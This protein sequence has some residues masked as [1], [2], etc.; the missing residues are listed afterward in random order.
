MSDD[1]ARMQLPVVQL[2][3]KVCQLV[4]QWREDELSGFDFLSGGYSN[5]NFAFTRSAPGGEERYVLRIPQN[6]QPYVSR[7][8]EITWYDQLPDTIGVRPL[9]LDYSSGQMISPWVE[10]KL[11]ID[12]FEETH[13]TDD[14]VSYLRRLH[15]ALPKVNRRYHVPSLLPEFIKAVEWEKSILAPIIRMLLEDALEPFEFATQQTCHNDLNPWNIIV[16]RSHWVT[17]DW[18][19]VGQNDPLFDVVGLHQGLGLNVDSLPS[20]ANAC[21]RGYHPQSL[22][23]AFGHFWIREWAWA[24]FQLTRGNLRDEIVEQSALAEQHLSQ[25]PEF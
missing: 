2:R 10:G 9:V 23:R 21:V 17:L 16:T 12:V 6:K 24:R 7:N 8:A 5:T 11:L 20:L 3:A 18:E 25:L 22:S 13:S 15:P 4:P 1:L 19:F 14:L